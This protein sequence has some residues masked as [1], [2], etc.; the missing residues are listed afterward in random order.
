M[1]M[2]KLHT[3]IQSGEMA[4]I[5]D[6]TRQ[7]PEWIGI[8]NKEGLTPLMQAIYTKQTEI[9]EMLLPLVRELSIFE[10]TVLGRS[11]QVAEMI[12]Q[13]P[14]M[15]R[16][17]SPGGYTILCLAVNFGQ[18]DTAQRLIDVGADVNQ[19]SRD[20]NNIRPIHGAMML[21][22]TDKALSISRLLLKKGACV[23]I[24]QKQGMTPLHLAV[25]RQKKHLVEILLKHGADISVTNHKNK[26]PY[27]LAVDQG[28]K[29]I[30][31][32]LRTN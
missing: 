19:P 20:M 4:R 12:K 7:H 9:V 10:A 22:D 30:A 23:N 11:M 21:E 2:N 8:P 32:L 28:F 29:D 18:R 13:S 14:E 6:L 31:R 16:A 1:V 27:E 26:T 17:Y 5:K 3:A 24:H 25:S 15:L